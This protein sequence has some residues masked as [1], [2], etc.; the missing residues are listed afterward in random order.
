MFVK[1][2]EAAAAGPAAAETPDPTPPSVPGP[3][4]TAG[5]SEP[6]PT[7]AS[8][9][10]YRYDCRSLVSSDAVRRRRTVCRVQ[11]Q[12][13]HDPSTVYVVTLL[14]KL[15]IYILKYLPDR[16]KVLHHTERQI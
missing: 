10:V 16:I 9:P 11:L 2:G 14:I 6:F 3:A 8:Q 5:Q 15:L 1:P 4:G 7:A 13:S 12:N